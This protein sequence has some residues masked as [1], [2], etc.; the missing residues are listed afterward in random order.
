MNDSAA[1]RA[2]SACCP[3]SRPSASTAIA[4]AGTNNGCSRPPGNPPM[5]SGGGCAKRRLR[6]QHEGQPRQAATRA[7]SCQP[8]QKDNAG[9]RDQAAGA[10]HRQAARG[11]A[12]QQAERD[13]GEMQQPGRDHEADAVGQRIGARPAI[14]RRG[15]GRGRSRTRRP[16]RPRSRSAAAPPTPPQDPAA[17]PKS[18]CRSRCRAAARP[19]CRARRRTP[20]PAETRPAAGQIAGGPRNAP[21]SPTAT[22]AAT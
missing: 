17:P 6:R 14:P 2:Q 8:R 7:R 22:I 16:A 12:R 3:I 13:A 4:C 19:E 5:P 21:H 1:S 20:S 18:R 11:P 10:A 9:E 15:R